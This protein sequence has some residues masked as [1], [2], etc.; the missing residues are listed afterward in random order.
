VPNIF[1]DQTAF[2]PDVK[3]INENRMLKVDNEKLME[4]F[5][6]NTPIDST[7]VSKKIQ[8]LVNENNSLHA[9]I[10]SGN[11]PPGGDS[12]K[13]LTN[14][15]NLAL[16]QLKTLLKR[17]E[18]SN[19]RIAGHSQMVKNSQELIN[20]ENMFY[21][22]L[23]NEYAKIGGGEYVSQVRTILNTTIDTDLSK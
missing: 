15:R 11:N 17:V 23:R 14:E 22:R 12:I 4:A 19:Q 13:Y 7:D 2:W 9:Q 20:Q 1:A 10:Q 6:T 3:M 5:K 18:E 8:E 16:L 21:N